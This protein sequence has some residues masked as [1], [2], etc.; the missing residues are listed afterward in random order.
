MLVRE[1]AFAVLGEL[2]EVDVLESRFDGAKAFAG[3]A[4]G[5]NTKLVLSA[6]QVSADQVEL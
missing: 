5:I 1:L 4:F 3:V 2:E 6:G